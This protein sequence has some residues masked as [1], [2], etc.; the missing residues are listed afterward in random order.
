MNELGVAPT[1]GWDAYVVVEVWVEVWTGWGKAGGL[2]PHGW[3]SLKCMTQLGT[4]RSF[5]I[6]PVN[7][8]L[9]DTPIPGQW[10][11]GKVPEFVRSGIHSS[12]L[13]MP[14]RRFGTVSLHSESLIMLYLHKACYCTFVLHTGFVE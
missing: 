14:P 13:E 11:A 4:A 5:Q 3:R 7:P 6:H 9:T 8:Q 2:Y 1:L 12:L 10:Q